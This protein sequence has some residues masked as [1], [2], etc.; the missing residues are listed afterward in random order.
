M[1]FYTIKFT[2]T[3]G[4]SGSTDI[5]GATPEEAK[6][7]A[8]ARGLPSM[9][10]WTSYDIVS[11]QAPAPAPSPAPSPAPAPPGQLSP[12]IEATWKKIQESANEMFGRVAKEGVTGAG[13]E[14]IIKPTIPGTE[15]KPPIIPTGGPAITADSGTVAQKTAQELL[16]EAKKADEA[17][18]KQEKEI[19]D[20]TRQKTI[21]SLKA[22]LGID[23]GIPAKPTLVSDYEALR[24]D[25]GVT[26]LE[27]QIN[28]LNTQIADTEASLRLGVQKEEGRLAPMELIGTRQ[29]ELRR[30]GQEQIDSLNRRKA[31][32]VD[33]YNTKVTLVNNIMNLKSKDYEWSVN[34]YNT[35]FT[36][37]VSLQNLLMTEDEKAK[38]AE[39]VARDDSRAN[40]TVMMNLMQGSNL[41]IDKMSDE[42]KV[43]WAKEAMKA[44]ISVDSLQAFLTARPGMKIDYTTSGTD[45]D[46]NEITSFFSYNNGNPTLV[47]TIK[48]GAIST[49]STEEQ[50]DINSF[51]DD[52]KKL[53]G[54]LA[55][56]SINWAEAWNKLHG[57]YPKASNELIDQ[58]LGLEYRIRDQ[59]K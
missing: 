47:K 24:S 21:A 41:T 57:M 29:T 52:A 7:T 49:K 8:E 38:A 40:L 6:K 39:N 56:Q 34:E 22:E 53:R 37:A 32:L 5:F 35:K 12:E 58:T 46:G 26:A 11:P 23:T 18:L 54:D 31:T 43:T 51:M 33:E 20:L 25:K 42:F 50:K 19:A 4:I 10:Q 16:D 9:N 27:G 1:P 17:R 48:T 13:G 59:G 2:K 55:T 28:A 36:Q 15:E 30:Q 44:G 14:T 45:A 3:G